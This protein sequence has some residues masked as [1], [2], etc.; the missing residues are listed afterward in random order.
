MPN[1]I[2]QTDDYL[3]QAIPPESNLSAETPQEPQPP[4]DVQPIGG[5]KQNQGATNFA[6]VSQHTDYAGDVVSKIK[7]DMRFRDQQK[8][9]EKLLQMGQNMADA[10]QQDAVKTYGDIKDEQGQP[11]ILKWIPPKQNFIDPKTGT[12]NGV[13]YAQRAYIG[14][15]KFEEKHEADMKAQKTRE[16]MASTAKENP[17][18]Q[19]QAIGGLTGK[20]VDVP[21]ND[22]VKAV[23]NGEQIEQNKLKQ[24]AQD[25][26]TRGQDIRQQTSERGQDIRQGTATRGQD[27]QHQDRVDAIKQRYDAAKKRMTTALS[28]RKKT[29]SSTIPSREIKGYIDSANRHLNELSVEVKAKGVEIEN[30]STEQEQMAKQEMDALKKEVSKTKADIGLWT[31]LAK[32]KEAEEDETAKKVFNSG[33]SSQTPPGIPTI[34]NK[35]DYA[36]L[37][38][39]AQ[40]Y[41]PDGKLRKKL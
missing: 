39:G 13:L 7:D 2:D 34:T 33:D 29:G 38:S 12:F 11:E 40:Y 22:F 4:R 6:S 32:Q 36:A 35:E 1:Q 19:M 5:A 37:K 16:A 26:T 8:Q 14:I 41:G 20:G 3:K 9:F 10:V 24:G 17:A 15:K 18:N 31:E 21:V 25:V 23:P 27:L 28:I 30:M